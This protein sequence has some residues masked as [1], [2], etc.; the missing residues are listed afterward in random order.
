M[1]ARITP[2]VVVFPELSGSRRPSA[3]THS[4]T[5]SAL[6]DALLAAGAESITIA[7][8]APGRGESVEPYYDRLGY[9]GEFW[10][11]PVAFVDSAAEPRGSVASGAFTVSLAVARRGF[12]PVFPGDWNPSTGRRERADSPSLRIVDAFPAAKRSG[13]HPPRWAR[14]GLAVAGFDAE[15][16]DVVA[17]RFAR[18]ARFDS[19]GP[20]GAAERAGALGR[21][22]FDPDRIEIIGDV[23]T[24]AVWSPAHPLR[25]FGRAQTSR[26]SVRN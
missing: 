15:A 12:G 5:L 6:V 8:A 24:R 11:R 26:R 13:P 20:G 14:P 25:M 17:A 21:G 19:G 4:G 3:S 18:F 22:G 1:T 23:P 7:A 16:V 2:E 10:G 9:R